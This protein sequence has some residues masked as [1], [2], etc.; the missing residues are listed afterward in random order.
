LTTQIKIA[1][2]GD[3]LMLQS[4]INSAKIRGQSHYSFRSMF[5]PIEPYIQSADLAIGNLESPLAGRE[6][7][8][9][10]RNPKTHYPMLNCP[11]ELAQALK[12]IGFH[13]LITA[14]NHC[15]DRGVKGLKRTLD[16]LDQYGLEHTGTYASRSSSQKLL[17]QDVQGIK[18]GLLAY[19]RGVNYNPYPQSKP[20]LVN[21]LREE[22]I[23]GDIRKLK[24]NSADLVVVALHFGKEFRHTPVEH[25][26]KWVE[27]LFRYGADIVL[28]C[29]PHVLQPMIMKRVKDGYGET[30]D[31]F[32]IYS[33]GNFISDEL[34]RFPQ[35]LDGIILNLTIKKD[36]DGVV[37][38]ADIDYIPTWIQRKESR[39]KRYFKVLSI[40]ECL[41]E[42]CSVSLNKEDIY[43]MKAALKR[44][45][46]ILGE[47]HLE[48]DKEVEE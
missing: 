33:L 27:K 2:V 13:T 32:A 31:R 17:I 8:Y 47:I 48:N 45:K 34:L 6:I 14:N 15:L 19:T 35:T 43:M 24:E 12:E 41:D 18:V 5:E 42:T 25:Q 11:D 21:R 36:D 30:K 1:V 39:G 3:I 23:K 4:Q 40:P 46:K 16:V 29:H 37:R 22:K 20:W 44:T 38:L 26:Q 7:R 28:G 9:Q 10:Q